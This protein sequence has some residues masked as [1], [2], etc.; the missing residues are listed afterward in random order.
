M[1]KFLIGIGSRDT[2]QEYIEILY[3]IGAYFA[4][5]G[6]VLRSGGAKGA[7]SA[8][9]AAYNSVGGKKEI[10]L[11]W[12]GFNNNPS[13]LYGVCS[14]ALKMG[15]ENHKYW[16]SLN[17]AAEKLIARN[18]YQVLGK[19]LNKPADILIC[20]TEAEGVGQ[21]GTC[22]TLNLAR[23]NNI[24]CYNIFKD[25]DLEYLRLNCGNY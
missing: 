4:K 21:G 3:N 15:A 17:E 23:K 24:E 11:P 1:S 18:C 19:S 16:A 25:E 22:F 12:Q 13:P 5:Q 10:Y 7:D 9:E 20:Y 14:K 2:P 8:F 6:Y